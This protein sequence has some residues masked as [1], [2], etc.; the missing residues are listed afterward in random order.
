MKQKYRIKN[1]DC[2]SCAAQIEETAKERG[3]DVT[4][5]FATQTLVVDEEKMPE[6]QKI[7]KRIEPEA[8]FENETDNAEEESDLKKQIIALVT[9][10]IVFAVA[11]IDRYIIP[12]MPLQANIALFLTS[13]LISGW[14]VL[15]SAI[16]NILRGN[17]FGENFLMSVATLG[18]IAIGEFPE[19]VAVMIFYSIGELFEDIAVGKSRRSIKS[20]LALKVNYTNLLSNGKVKKVPP[21]NVKPGQIILINPGERVPLDGAILEGESFLDT[22]ALT[23]ESVPRKVKKG[24]TILSGMINTS[25]LL[26]VE[27]QKSFE[28]SYISKIL[29]LVENAASKKAPTEKF[30]TKFSKYYTPF[31]VFGAMAI[32]FLPPLLMPGT[33]MTLWVQR[34]LVLLVIS[35]PC[36]LVISI[37][38]GYF[39]GLG[40]ASKNGV[41]IKGGNYL[42]ALRNVD[43]V[44]F[45]KTG[46][47]T[48]GVFEVARVKAFN[49]YSE[50]E[51]ME[52]A[53]MAE[54]YSNHP[55]ARSICDYD[56]S[57][58]ENPNQVRN[59][60]E[61][62]GQGVI[63]EVS[64]KKV[65]VGNKKL[66]E[67]YDIDPIDEEN[68]GTLVYVAIDGKYAGSIIISDRIK[69]DAK[70]A[71]GELRKY[72][73]RKIAMLTGD[74]QIVAE[75][76]ASELG[77]DEYYSELLPV[78]KVSILERLKNE[79]KGKIVFV[80]DG[81]NDSP[82]LARADIGVAMGG[83]G[84]D[85]AIETA[86]VVIMDDK[87]SKLSQAMK[88]ATITHNIVLQNILFALGTKGLFIALGSVGQAT[89]W[90]AV[91]AD[92]GV[93]LLAVLNAT[94]I[95]KASKDR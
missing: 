47:L 26:K 90:E 19:A 29:E 70:G 2:A 71:I 86:D 64:G 88:I 14:P 79:S 17:L 93:A 58:I 67:S 49:G 36:A 53:A 31:V 22:S 41:L 83:L 4:L 89:M 48:E 34:A 11:L 18:A 43:T 75:K 20:L 62:P 85:A 69:A 63:A 42:D 9:S 35:C 32:A 77:I 39:G 1:L 33:S 13:Y 27:V 95:L 24:D 10:G 55:V 52:F 38:L 50:K 87:P 40:R 82:V 54:A 68:G 73:V 59:Y 12:F 57:F 7:A 46:T 74:S 30:I 6:L 21:E 51:I 15:V 3:I 5:N 76:V 66:L 65:Y 44:V 56:K 45:D 23:G 81:I 72:G 94:R 8:V 28:N 78:D 84:S 25:G 61:I 91:F 37:P 92:V 60:K 16:K 80:G